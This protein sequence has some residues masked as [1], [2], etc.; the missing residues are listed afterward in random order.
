MKVLLPLFLLTLPVLA[1]PDHGKAPGTQSAESHVTGNGKFTFTT[2]PGWGEMPDGKNVGPTHGGVAV[3]KAGNTYVST[4][5][6]H[7]ICK[8]DKD[9]KFLKSFG[10]G[11]KR[12]HSLAIATVNGKE[13]LYG[14]NGRD[15]AFVQLDLDGKVLMRI[16]N[17]NTGEVQGGYRAKN[18]DGS[19]RKDE[20]GNDVMV[21]PFNG[22]TAAAIAPDGTVFTANGYGNNLIHKFDKTGKLLNTFGGRSSKDDRLNKMKFQTCHGLAVDTRFDEPR[23]LVV[24]RENG[25]LLHYSLNFDYIDTYAENLR[26]PCA[27]SFYKDELATAE[28]AGRVTIINKAGAP[29]AFLGDNPDES[30]RANFKVEKAD[31]KPQFFTA[32]HG[33]SYDANG[34]LIVQDWN[35]SGRVTFLKRR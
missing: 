9:G 5:A 35:K 14:A 10:Q 34:N 7:G 32:P 21:S 24:D 1:H 13:V 6:N 11:T 30:Q 15:R 25:R 22:I 33:L 23:L 17:E 8:F 4:D 31:M 2:V 12:F 18:K 3:D 20:D 29:V 26:R 16:P 28:L 27:V 19:I